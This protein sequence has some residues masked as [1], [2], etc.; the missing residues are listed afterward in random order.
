M[1][2]DA[3]AAISTILFN[4]GCIFIY[5]HIQNS[6]NLPKASTILTLIPGAKTSRFTTG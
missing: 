6:N 1:S 5:I 2:T 3:E 4:S